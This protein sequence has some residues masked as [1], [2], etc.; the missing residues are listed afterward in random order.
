MDIIIKHNGIYLKNMNLVKD[1][2][3]V[4]AVLTLDDNNR[5]NVK[6]KSNISSYTALDHPVS[7]MLCVIPK[8]VEKSN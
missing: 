4:V 8:R 5:V 7:G 1:S 3:D 2:S 6:I